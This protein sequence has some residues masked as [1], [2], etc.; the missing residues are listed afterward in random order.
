MDRSSR[1]FVPGFPCRSFSVAL[2]A[3]GVAIAFYLI[4]TA[5]A[6]TATTIDLAAMQTGQP[7]A[8][9]AFGRTGQ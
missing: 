9:F 5:A 8:G 2:L 7:P 1:V 6:Q 3:T 4:A